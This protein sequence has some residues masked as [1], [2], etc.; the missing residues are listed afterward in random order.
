MCHG[1]CLCTHDAHRCPSH[2]LHDQRAIKDQSIHNDILTVD[3]KCRTSADTPTADLTG[4]ITQQRS[5]HVLAIVDQISTAHLRSDLPGGDAERRRERD[6][7]LQYHWDAVVAHMT[8]LWFR[9]H[10]WCR[11]RQLALASDSPF[12]P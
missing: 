12:K 8:P 4:G 1:E 3:D 10:A 2:S 6:R 11:D 9:A 7:R 5:I